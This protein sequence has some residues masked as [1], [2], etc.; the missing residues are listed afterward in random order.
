MNDEFRLQ[1]KIKYVNEIEIKS[2]NFR[3][4]YETSERQLRTLKFY[5]NARLKQ[6]AKNR[7]KKLIA[8]NDA[9]E[10]LTVEQKTK[11]VAIKTY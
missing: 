10:N 5:E 9:I 4:V 8:L 3:N 2:K 11:F 6:T 7:E 1:I